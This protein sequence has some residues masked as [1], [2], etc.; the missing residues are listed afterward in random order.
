MKNNNKTENFKEKLKQA[1]NSTIKVIS[2]EIEIKNPEEK[3]Q[4]QKKIDFLNLENLNSK[5][6]FIN[7]RAESDSLALKMKFSNNEIYKKNLPLN[8]SCKSLYSIAEKIRYESLGFKMLKGIQ[9][10]ISDSYRLAIDNKLAAD[11]ELTITQYFLFI[12]FAKLFSNVFTNW[13][14]VNLSLSI[15]D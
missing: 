6:D 12:N 5:N 7:A 8:L 15:T 14:I 13:P 4:N 11:P 10:N 2:E 3:S 1:L 9:K